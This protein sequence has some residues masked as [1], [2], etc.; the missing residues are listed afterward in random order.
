[1]T[2]TDIRPTHFPWFRYSD[3]TFSLGLSDPDT[4]AAYLSGHS[5]SAYEPEEG[6]IVVRGGMAEQAETAYA[7]VGRILEAADLDWPDVTS[8]V[9]YVTV[10]GLE[11]YPEAQ[12]VR[13]KHFPGIPPTVR[14]VVVD[15][16]LRPAALVEIEVTAARSSESLPRGV[17]GGPDAT[18]QLPS[19]LPVDESGGAVAEGDLAGQ[20]RH[21]LE[22]AGELLAALGLGLSDVVKTVDFSTPVTREAYPTAARVRRD[23]LG[24]VYPAATG[25]LMSR[26]AVPGALVGLEVTASRDETTAINPG[27]TRYDTLTYS[28]AV[29]AGRTLHLSGFAALDAET[30]QPLHPGDVEAQA[31]AIYAAVGEVLAAAGLGPEHLVRTVEYVTPDGLRGY[32]AV[33]GVRQ[34]RLARPF[35]AS[36]G[37]VC[38][39]LLRPELLLEVDPTAVFPAKQRPGRQP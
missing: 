26:L 35:P 31:D 5:A 1:V 16:L 36:T 8:L 20:Y 18:V 27:W 3:Y 12:E 28:P 14:T 6:R 25:I 39:G 13:R 23:L 38:A 24:P 4:G 34:R 22:A 9:E 29:R 11:S 10:A 33:A 30:Q 15:R 37:I 7:K 2:V 21:C 32:R 19:L 17:R